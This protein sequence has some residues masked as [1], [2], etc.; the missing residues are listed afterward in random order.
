M[1]K[2]L[3]LAALVVAVATGASAGGLTVK[4]GAG[5]LTLQAKRI[6]VVFTPMP[7]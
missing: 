1:L 4:V 2:Q 5:Y 3:S 7:K 6:L